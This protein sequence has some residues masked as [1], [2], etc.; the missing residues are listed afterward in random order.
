[1][2]YRYSDLL[3]SF[4]TDGWFNATEAAVHGYTP[5]LLYLLAELMQKAVAMGILPAVPDAHEI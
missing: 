5:T 4:T 2:Q 1:V 3:Y